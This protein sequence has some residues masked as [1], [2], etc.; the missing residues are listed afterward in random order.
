M[1]LDATITVVIIM[2]RKS[3]TRR[4]EK[5][6]MSSLIAGGRVRGSFSSIC[7]AYNPAKTQ[8]A[9]TPDT[10]MFGRIAKRGNPGMLS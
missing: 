7:S 2:R 4:M 1:A 8:L 6:Q 5:F 9:N 3:F 10:K